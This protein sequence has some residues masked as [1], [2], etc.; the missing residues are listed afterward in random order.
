MAT[1]NLCI[2]AGMAATATV[3]NA[4][5]IDGGGSESI[6]ARTQSPL[7]S[8]FHPLPGAGPAEDNELW[9]LLGENGSIPSGNAAGRQARGHVF[10]AGLGA[11]GVPV[12]GI[13]PEVRAV[14]TCQN[15]AVQSQV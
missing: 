8:G 2:F 3:P 15:R 7:P 1:R 6:S 12:L 5:G 9:L 10:A 11:G 4:A 14:V 13:V